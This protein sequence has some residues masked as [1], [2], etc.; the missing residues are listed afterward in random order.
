MEYLLYCLIF[1]LCLGIQKYHTIVRIRIRRE[2]G[3]Q[4]VVCRVIPLQSS[5]TK[6]SKLK[7]F[8]HSD[9]DEDPQ[10]LPEGYSTSKSEVK[11]I[12]AKNVLTNAR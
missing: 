10:K 3:N 2:N 8:L 7:K 6:H 5:S 11:V 12:F 9:V 1:L 4:K